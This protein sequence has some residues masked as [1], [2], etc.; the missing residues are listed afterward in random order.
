MKGVIPGEPN[1]SVLG[2]QGYLNHDMEDISSS[3]GAT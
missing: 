3:R 2:V 1:M